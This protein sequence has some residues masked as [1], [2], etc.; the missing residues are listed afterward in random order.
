MPRQ[1]SAA[2]NDER[3]NIIIF[4]IILTDNN[5]SVVFDQGEK[6]VRK[7]LLVPSLHCSRKPRFPIGRFL[8]RWMHT[9]EALTGWQN[10]SVKIYL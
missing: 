6:R 4:K 9:Q 7:M 2:H 1:A 5:V 10:E 8:N 3:A